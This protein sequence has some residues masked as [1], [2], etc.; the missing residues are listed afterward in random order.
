MR[1]STL[2]QNVIANLLGR[3]WSAL[4]ALAF[5]PVY[6]GF[7]GIEGYA[8]VGFSLTL[9]AVASILDLGIGTTLNRELARRA[10]RPEKAQSMRDFV[11]TLEVVHWSLATVIGIAILATA[12]FIAH[13]WIKPSVLSPETIERALRLM[14]IAIAF[15]WPLSLYSGGLLGLERQLSL[16][17]IGATMATV[18][19]LGAVLVLWRISPTVEAFFAWQVA[20]SFF[21][22]AWIA[23]ALWRA[24]P[25]GVKAA[26]FRP[27]LVLEIGGF[28]A[29]VSG[30]SILSVILTQLDKVLL[31]ALLP[32]ETF[33]Y[34]T[35]AGVVAA[36]AMIAVGPIFAALFPRFSRLV[37][38][39]DKAALAG[40]YH[41]ASQLV[42]VSMLPLAAIIV[43]FAYEVLA[44]WTR[45][46]VI[47]QNSAALAALITAGAALNASLN[48]P[49]ALQLAYG[50]TRLSLAIGLGNV[51][52]LG[53]L[54]YLATVRYE[55]VGAATVWLVMNGI[56]ILVVTH[57]LHRRYL[58]GEKWRWLLGDLAVPAIAAFGVA[59]AA[60]AALPSD[61]SDSYTL[62]VLAATAVGATLS[63]VAVAPAI[64]G[65]ARQAIARMLS[66]H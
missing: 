63:V 32:L 46:P 61:A 54:V 59:G 41:A 7:L 24:L 27:E 31:S 12:P 17:A 16:N 36:A 13:Q 4:M 50:W 58:P 38:D 26:A 9:F 62:G 52:L 6:I 48:M 14:G 18:R 29:G 44:L 43:F 51:I 15:Q 66:A 23:I 56:N 21:Q 25:R 33:G 10:G 55:A 5:V 34:Y 3:G 49:Y 53:P 47:A 2:K 57:A 45:D 1:L 30:I 11:R 19:G 8:L 20:T 42:S 60:R 40:L 39:G 22:T 65:F 37:S 35:L 64:R 28:A